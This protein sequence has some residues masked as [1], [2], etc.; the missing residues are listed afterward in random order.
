M[1]SD[2]LENRGRLL[3]AATAL[4]ARDGLG[5]PLA[6]VA[7]QAGVGIGTLYRHFP[8]RAELLEALVV[9]SLEFVLGVLNTVRHEPPIDAL[10]DYFLQMIAGRDR[11]ILPLR[12]GPPITSPQAA[13]LRGDLRAVIDELLHRGRD[14]GTVRADITSRDIVVFATMLA[15]P[16]PRIGD[17]DAAARRTATVY[18][19]GLAPGQ[20][21]SPVM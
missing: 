17:W 4:V 11:L 19:A 6:A 13:A 9:R 5:V 1:R 20:P 12:G 7:E 8:G 2:G 14:D 3:D 16:L 21:S 15:Q 18:L 10:R